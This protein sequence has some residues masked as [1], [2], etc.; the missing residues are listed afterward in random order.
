[1]SYLHQARP[2]LIYYILQKENRGGKNIEN[3]IIYLK[4]YEACRIAG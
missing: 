1:M 4:Q 3:E 2:A